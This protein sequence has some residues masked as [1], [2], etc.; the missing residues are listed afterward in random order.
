VGLFNK[1]FDGAR[2]GLFKIISVQLINFIAIAIL[3]RVLDLSDFGLVALANSALIFFNIFTTQG[4]NQY[5][6]YDNSDKYYEKVNAVF[7]LNL[8]ISTTIMIIA[9]LMIPW[10][11]TFL[12]EPLLGDILLILFLR[13]PFDVISKLPDAILHKNL[14]FKQIEIRDTV[15]Q[16]AT[17][18]GSVLMALNGFGVWS[19]I[20]PSIIALPIRLII[21]FSLVTW[22]P[23]FRLY[24]SHW[25]KIL[26]YSKHIVGGSLANYTLTQGDTIM[27]GSIFGV[28]SLGVYNL[29]WQSSNLLSRTIVTLINK[30]AF[31][32]FSSFKGDLN[33]IKINLNKV[34][35]SISIISFPILMWMLV[36]AEYLILTIYGGKWVD[37]IL[38]FQILLIYAIR[39]SVGA[40]IG[41][42][43][44][45]LGRPD[46]IFKLG[47]SIIPFYL[48]GIWIGSF[49]NIIGVAIAVTFV[50]TV[51]GLVSFWIV[52]HLLKTS[53]F[54]II[55]QLKTPF[56]T[57]LIM[58]LG[59]LI[60]DELVLKYYFNLSSLSSLLILVIFGFILY[61]CLIKYIFTDIFTF[62]TGLYL[63]IKSK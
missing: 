25:K 16:F 34:L 41:S 22:R 29:A 10:I 2:W 46:L 37:A 7:W 51:F 6:I 3:S 32:A 45:S 40:P 39:Y 20:I 14:K 23:I 8:I 24:Y 54:T 63:K 18:C 44:K 31:P 59:C 61:F 21:S 48:L 9:V 4:I 19:L 17:S 52:A 50:R 11:K 43:F 33:L 35:F 5:L 12:N 36:S 62:L 56:I 58:S 38:P 49:Y 13:L 27:V 53:F 26:N 57:S 15:L 60:L 42:V 47:V 1:V 30:I 55:K 28:T